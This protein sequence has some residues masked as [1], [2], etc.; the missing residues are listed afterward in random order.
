MTNKM[1]TRFSAN[2]MDES[3]YDAKA[4][5][6]FIEV[7]DMVSDAVQTA[8]KGVFIDTSALPVILE[9]VMEIEPFA[10]LAVQRECVETPVCGEE[11]DAFAEGYNVLRKGKAAYLA[12]S[13]WHMANMRFTSAAEEPE[14]AWYAFH[15]MLT[16]AETLVYYMDPEFRKP[17][18]YPFETKWFKDEEENVL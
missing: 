6:E 18:D 5:A 13:L 17:N 15:D 1:E 16:W 9:R 4:S 11:Y 8:P 12:I 10:A 7:F 3:T 2:G 14:G